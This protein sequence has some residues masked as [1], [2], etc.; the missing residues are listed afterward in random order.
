MPDLS[1]NI[2]HT[3]A[4]DALSIDH[5][6]AQVANLEHAAQRMRDAGF[7]LSPRSDLSNVG[8]ANHLVLFEPVD[9]SCASYFELMIPTVPLNAL[10]PS[11]AKV[12]AGKPAWRWLVL[13]TRNALVSHQ[14]LTA[15]GVVMP[16]PLHVRRQWMIS[17]SES[18]WPEFDVTFPCDERLPFNLCQYHNVSLYQRAEWM[19]HPNGARQLAAVIAVDPQPEV[20]ARDYARWFGTKAHRLPTGA[21]R[22][23][24]HPTCLEIWSLDALTAHYGIA[25]RAAGYVG[26][27]V[28]YP[29]PHRVEWLLPEVDGFIEFV[30]ERDA[31][32]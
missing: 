12:L 32:N 19:R 17:P 4:S 2:N 31:V 30:N 8:V 20:T 21:W 5:V 25:A 11:M 18:V 10:H 3:L 6:V 27:R 22:V 13:A 16:A 15:D 24:G 23:A 1:A 29:G 9:W 26:I 14:R 28:R 7:T